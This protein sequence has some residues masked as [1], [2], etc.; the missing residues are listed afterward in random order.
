M[1]NRGD[2]VHTADPW[3]AKQNDRTNN[4]RP[5]VSPALP[6]GQTLAELWA[7]KVGLNI[8]K[9]D[10][11]SKFL[12]LSSAWSWQELAD[13]VHEIQVSLR[14]SEIQNDPEAI[15][16]TMKRWS[17]MVNRAHSRLLLRGPPKRN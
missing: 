6:D 5:R 11:D 10:V 12:N 1:A 8:D 15:R 7:I 13:K 2:V 4:Q 14:Q 9:E 3:Q 16:G 17:T